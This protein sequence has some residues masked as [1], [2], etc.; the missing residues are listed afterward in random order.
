M[1]NNLKCEMCK[2]KTKCVALNKLQPFLEDA[3]TVLGV[4]LE[5]TECVDYSEYVEEEDEAE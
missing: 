1:V 2:F 4:T 3:H 5:F